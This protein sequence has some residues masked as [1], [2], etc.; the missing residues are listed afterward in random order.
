MKTTILKSKF[1]MLLVLAVSLF[2]CEPDDNPDLPNPS[3]DLKAEFI[4]FS[5]DPTSDFAGDATITANIIN[6]GDDFRSGAGQQSMLLYEKQLGVPSDQ[7]GDLVAR[8]DFTSLAAG[9]KL[10]VSYRRPWNASSPAEGEFP[11]EY[12]L[13]ISYDPDLYADSNVHND[14]TNSANDKITVSGSLINQMFIDQ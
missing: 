12:I 4:I 11:P 14:D 13:V 6:I 3:I 5:V 7:P 9:D 2:S 8:L 1:F 10:E